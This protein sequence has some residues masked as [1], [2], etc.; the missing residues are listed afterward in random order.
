M[1]VLFLVVDGVG[2]TASDAVDD[3]S[4]AIARTEVILLVIFVVEDEDG[5]L[6][7]IGFIVIYFVLLKYY[8][9]KFCIMCLCLIVVNQFI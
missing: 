8:F 7:I 5:I 3:V 2:A 9:L 4:H 1:V 6:F